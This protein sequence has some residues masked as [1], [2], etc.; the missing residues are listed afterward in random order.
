M[1][2]AQ[3]TKIFIFLEG[4][5]TASIKCPDGTTVD[6]EIPRASLEGKTMDERYHAINERARRYIACLEKESADMTSPDYRPF[7]VEERKG[8]SIMDILVGDQAS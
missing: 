2:D 4:S 7:Q 5:A 3:I 1:N 6:I 8:V